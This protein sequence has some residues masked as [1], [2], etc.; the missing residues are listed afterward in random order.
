MIYLA[1]LGIGIL[2][3]GLL[4]VLLKYTT[5]SKFNFEGR[6]Y[7]KL[8][9]FIRYFLKDLKLKGESILSNKG[10][11]AILGIAILVAGTGNNLQT[12]IKM[13]AYGLLFG[14]VILSV[15]IKF[16]ND[17][18]RVKK[19]KEITI[20]FE[21]IE[22]YT[23]SGYTL[24]QALR[25]AKPMTNL[26]K[27]SIN[28]CLNSWNKGPLKALEILR[29][30]LNMPESDTLVLLLAHME[31][32]GKNNLEGMLKREATNIDHLQNIRAKIKIA[33]RPLILMIYRM[34]PLFS[35]IGIVVGGLLYRSYKAMSEAGIWHFQ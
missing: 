2:S 28:K 23:M 18:I 34:L 35:V 10:K 25:V 14:I 22:L 1:A 5:K 33:S 26:I 9:K 7:S 11:I 8:D 29:K 17:A 31:T 27:P 15:I 13:F 24:Y 6:N 19:L 16:R 3:I 32:S 12:S 20:L 21:A 4:L 30:D